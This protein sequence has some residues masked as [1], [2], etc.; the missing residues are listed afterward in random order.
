MPSFDR[1]ARVTVRTRARPAVVFPTCGRAL[2]IC[3]VAFFGEGD[4]DAEFRPFRHGD[5]ANELAPG[6]RF[7]CRRPNFVF[8]VSLR[9]LARATAVPNFDRIAIVTARPAVVLPTGALSSRFVAFPGDGNRD[10]KFRPSHQSNRATGGSLSDR[11]PSS[12][13]RSFFRPVAELFFR[14]VAFFGEGVRDAKFGPFRQNNRATDL[15]AGSRFSDRRPSLVFSFRCV[16][17]RG[18]PRCPVSTD[19]P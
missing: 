3:L 4:R 8:F 18:R 1:F 17:R 6:G 11:Q 9:F 19:S 12:E 7:S 2:F 16:F 5:R 10:A 14:F 13:R 15:A